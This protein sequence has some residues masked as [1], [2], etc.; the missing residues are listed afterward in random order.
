MKKSE[1]MTVIVVAL[2]SILLAFF[3]T[4]SIFG[5]IY[6]GTAKIRVMKR[7]TSEIVEPDSEIFNERAINP[8]VRVQ[9]DRK[10]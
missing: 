2:T 1:I 5:D 6:Q 10:Q 9:I 7:I 3:I 4:R 8:T